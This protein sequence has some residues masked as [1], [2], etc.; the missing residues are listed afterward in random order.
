MVAY[1]RETKL[2]K[3]WDILLVLLS[4]SKLNSTETLHWTPKWIVLSI[5]SL[6]QIIAVAQRIHYTWESLCQSTSVMQVVILRSA[7]GMQTLKRRA[8][9]EALHPQSTVQHGLP[10]SVCKSFIYRMCEKKKHKKSILGHQDDDQLFTT[11]FTSC[12]A[13]QQN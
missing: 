1:G 9:T 13:I 5:M 10:Y 8:N 4:L 7:T 3:H 12:C 11:A 6:I 2:L